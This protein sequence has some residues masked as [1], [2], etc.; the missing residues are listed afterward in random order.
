MKEHGDQDRGPK[1]PPQRPAIRPFLG[2]AIASFVALLAI[3]G[4]QSYRDLAAAHAREAEL[5]HEIEA[6]EERIGRLGER[7]DRLESDPLTLERLAREE[8]GLVKPGDVVIVLP[9]ESEAEE[10]E[11]GTSPD[12][13]AIDH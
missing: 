3:A 8:L 10:S 11:P 5:E 7:L 9:P 1:A 13:E 6:A 4:V 12:T 2:V